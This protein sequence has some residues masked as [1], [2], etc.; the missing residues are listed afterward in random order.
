MKRERQY[1][2]KTTAQIEALR[3]KGKCFKCERKGCRT[4]VCRVPSVIKSKHRGP[5]IYAIYLPAISDGMCE[6]DD[7]SFMSDAKSS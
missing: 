6:E 2:E 4:H 7:I 5:R 1:K 3:R